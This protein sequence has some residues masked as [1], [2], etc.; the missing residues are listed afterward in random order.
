MDAKG[1]PIPGTGVYRING[2][3]AVAR[4]IGDA[5]ERPYVSDVA[6]MR[7][8]T[9]DSGLDDFIILASDGL[10]DV[11]S[12]QDAVSFVHGIQNSSVG[13]MVVGSDSLKASRKLTEWASEHGSDVDMIRAAHAKRKKRMAKFLADE[14][15]RKGSGDNI[16]VIVLWL[17]E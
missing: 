14:A 1:K 16:C 9:V 11:M 10:W 3:L 12:S 7:R 17:K 8:L 13:G 2:N 4:A 5:S 6:E 15:M